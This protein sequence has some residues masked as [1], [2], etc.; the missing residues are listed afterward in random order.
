MF[1]KFPFEVHVRSHEELDE[2]I[3]YLSQLHDLGFNTDFFEKI[4]TN[5]GNGKPSEKPKNLRV[6]E[7]VEEFKNEFR[8][9]EITEEQLLALFNFLNIFHSGIIHNTGENKFAYTLR[10]T[11]DFNNNFFVDYSIL[12]TLDL[13]S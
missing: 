12:R 6:K 9:I 11:V 4:I 7:W 2:R 1:E 13:K 3:N 10:E 8:P 5:L